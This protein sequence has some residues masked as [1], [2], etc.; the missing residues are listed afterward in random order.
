[1][2][3]HNSL[4]LDAD[5][6]AR[7]ALA[8]P[9]QDPLPDRPIPSDSLRRGR[10]A[11]R[12][13]PWVVDGDRS[14]E[15]V[16]RKDTT[17]PYP[18]GSGVE[19]VTRLDKAGRKRLVRVARPLPDGWDA[20][21]LEAARRSAAGLRADTTRRDDDRAADTE[22]HAALERSANQALSRAETARDQALAAR[23]HA[24][25]LLDTYRETPIGDPAD[26][27]RYVPREE[28]I[29]RYWR[30]SDFADRDREEAR[31]R[32]TIADAQASRAIV[33]ASPLI[34]P[35]EPIAVPLPAVASR[36]RMVG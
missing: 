33:H 27:T 20:R 7:L 3:R 25:G 12:S 22:R 18:H 13:H 23:D 6:L 8:K 16:R 10:E 30:A 5:L 28:A 11:R 15:F 32:A 34:R 24:D 4:R 21:R 14:Q 2:K 26:P 9:G 29:L 36:R 19:E 35:M 1:M 31:R 17:D